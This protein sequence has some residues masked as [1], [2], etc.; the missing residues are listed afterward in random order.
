MGRNGVGGTTVGWIVDNWSQLGVV[1]GKAGLMYAL[2]VFGLRI[3]ER[4]TVAQW[5]IVD[6]V[7]AV[8]IGAI[9]GRT[10]VAA[11]QSFATGAVALLTLIAVHRLVS[12]LRFHPRLRHL[13]DHRVRVLVHEGA[14][15]RG[16]LRRCGLVDE[17]VFAKLREH[18][19]FDLAELQFLLSESKGA[20]TIVRRE[21]PDST[22]LISVALDGAA[23]F[24]L[25]HRR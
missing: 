10:A 7:T 21:V 14:L 8:A 19:V 13:F 11:Q 22:P 3:G 23:G 6:F 17:G 16:E 12:V 2:A 15:R 20:L 5:T 25:D 9:V 1:A 18:G 4:R 24:T